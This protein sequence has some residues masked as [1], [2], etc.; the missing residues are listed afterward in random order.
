MTA[1]ALPPSKEYIEN[2]VSTV[3]A[4]PFRFR[5]PQ[6]ITAKR[7]STAGAV[8]TLTYGFDYTVSGGATDTGGTLTVT[9]PAVAGTK[10]V[11]RR[12]TPRAQTMDYT[13]SDT[14]PAESH[15]QALDTAMLIDQE[16]DV[17]IGDVTAR[18]LKVEDGL[19][20]PEVD[21]T[22]LVEFELLQFRDGKLKR[23]DHAPFAGKFFV[24]GAGGLLQPS[25]GTGSDASF[26]VD[27]ANPLGLL[28]AGF[29]HSPAAP[30][31]QTRSALEKLRE[32]GASTKDTGCT[33]NGIA[34]DSDGLEEIFDY[35]G[36]RGG[37]WNLPPGVYKT[38]REIVVD[39][40]EPQ[41]ITGRGKRGVYPGLFAVDPDA[42]QSVIMP[43]HNGRNAIRFTGTV[44]GDGTVIMRNV[45]VATLEAGLVPTAA[46]GWDTSEE[47]YRDFIFEHVSVHG[48]TS[49]FD[50]YQTAGG[51]NQ[52][53][54]FRARYCNINRNLWVARTLGATQWNGFE[55]VDNEAGQNGYSIG[56][57]GINVSAHNAIVTGNALE[58][59]RD[60]VRIYG[61]MRGVTVRDNYFEAC[62]GE[63]SVHLEGLRGPYELGPNTHLAV[64]P[65]ALKHNHLVSNCGPGNNVGPYW[66]NGVYKTPL[67][68]VGNS[69]GGA[70]NILNPN[71]DTSTYGYY[72]MDSLD[73]GRYQRVPEFITMTKQRVTISGRELAPWNGQ[74]MPVQ[75]YTT[76]G[77]GSVALNYA[78]AGAS[79]TW[80]VVSWLFRREPDA[81][82]AS[83]PYLSLSVN[84]TGAAGSKDYVANAFDE[85]WRQGEWC[86]M[87]AAVRLGVAMTSLGV[88][89]F[90]FGIGPAAGR[91]IR[92][93]RPVVYVADSPSKIVPYIDDF[94]ARSVTATPNV[95]GFEQADILINA[96]V[97]A[98]GQAE[99]VKLAGADNNWAYA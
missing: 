22:G 6:H 96:A 68:V 50:L 72:R 4:V 14:F 24:G 19:T 78:I 47:F 83:D 25:D 66:P 42:G 84:G 26:R 70:D 80:A 63:A 8:T 28:L 21:L 55:F 76:A 87:T 92:F 39:C 46:F 61:G 11:I 5:N 65:G 94:T 91:K 33:G 75:E 52:A 44:V 49:A 95:P 15:E 98:G 82:A 32:I 77:A 54:L 2:G 60:P 67:P 29:S 34:D 59:M 18:S 88:S 69:L 58:G 89:L 9:T 64:D 56:H 45:A 3:F 73:M 43:V 41:A 40:S 79:G 93:I 31:I 57:G 10:L 20:A 36:A 99:F 13:T 71:V 27:V 12:E 85:Y 53:G 30:F 97:A 48:F 23:F 1:A 17:K 7:V 16:Q 74:P 51:N 81:G 35:F 37:Q 62:V 38:T 90:P 86:L